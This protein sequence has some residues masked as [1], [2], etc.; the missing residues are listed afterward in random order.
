MINVY[1]YFSMKTDGIKMQMSG[2][3]EFQQGGSEWI[4]LAEALAYLEWLEFQR[5]IWGY[6]SISSNS[7]NQDRIN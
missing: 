7:P 4:D 5:I 6:D 2:Q 3:V 1:Y